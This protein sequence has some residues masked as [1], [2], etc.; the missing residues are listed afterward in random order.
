MHKKGVFVDASQRSN[1][2]SLMLQEK[3]LEAFL[4]KETRSQNGEEIILDIIAD[5]LKIKKEKIDLQAGFDEL[6]MDSVLIYSFIQELEKRQLSISMTDLMSCK[7]IEDL[8]F[9]FKESDPKTIKS[10]DK[11]WEVLKN[12]DVKNSAKSVILIPG[13]P[14]ISFPYMSMAN[15][16]NTSSQVIG[17]NWKG[18]FDHAPF[19]SIEEVAIFNLE[20]IKQN[21]GNNSID[22]IGHSYGALIVYEMVKLADKKGV[23]IDE[24]ILIDST[25][26]L[27]SKSISENQLILMLLDAFGWN[28]SQISQDNLI[29]IVE[30]MLQK[31]IDEKIDYFESIQVMLNDVKMPQILNK[32]ITASIFKSYMKTMSIKYSPKKKINKKVKVIKAKI[33]NVVKVEEMDQGW[34]KLFNEVE[35]I[36]AEGDHSSIIQKGTCDLWINQIN[37]NKIKKNNSKSNILL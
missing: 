1:D 33:D 21:L 24:V 2:L 28:E 23:C 18:V 12:A 17:M 16:I 5:V 27:L 25:P 6:G 7:N 32:E 10:D 30:N 35:V 34:K 36:H 8:L 3:T 19:Q 20:Q 26:K 11:Y 31:T 14:G 29:D 37:K 15:A 22:L 4:P 9:Y 13:T